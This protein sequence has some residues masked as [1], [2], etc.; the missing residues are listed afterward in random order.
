MTENMWL[1][2]DEAYSG[3]E[4]AV[5]GVD[6]AGRG[7][8]AG[9]VFAAA[10]VLPRGLIIPGLDDSKKLT[11]KKREALFDIIVDKAA[12]YGVAS[13][14][15]K[16]IDEVNILNA[17]YLAMNRA[18]EMIKDS[19]SFALIDGN[20]KEG[21]DY[22]C[23]TVIGGDGK[24]ASIAAAS[25]LAKVSRDRYITALSEKYPEYGFSRHKGYGTREHYEALRKYGPCDIHRL[26]FLKKLH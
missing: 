23:R 22:P 21:I 11:A 24:S 13:A 2:E 25:V 19:F 10:V 17:T 5:C 18:M 8:L 6:E 3:G 26:T 20:R 1:Y 14:S 12:A 4:T 16:E 9:P 15:E 7:P